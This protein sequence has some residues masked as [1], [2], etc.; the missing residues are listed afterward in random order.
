[1]VHK[2]IY[3]PQLPYSN[4]A[5][6]HSYCLCLG[7]CKHFVNSLSSVGKL[8]CVGDSALLPVDLLV[9]FQCVG[10][11]SWLIDLLGQGFNCMVDRPLSDWASIAW[12]IDL[13]VMGLQVHG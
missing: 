1:M 3:S 9:G 10:F 12:L 2:Y 8:Q 11:N 5:S 13:L 7:V 4:T 6:E